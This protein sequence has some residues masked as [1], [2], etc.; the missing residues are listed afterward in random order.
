MK[1]HS[2]P[3]QK[4]Y[5]C[6]CSAE[7]ACGTLFTLADKRTREAHTIYEHI[8]FKLQHKQRAP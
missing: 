4:L 2:V 3:Q 6:P 7:N 8:T 1:S 5:P